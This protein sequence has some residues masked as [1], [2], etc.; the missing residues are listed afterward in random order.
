[1]ETFLILIVCVYA[2]LFIIVLVV[3]KILGGGM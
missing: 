3:S 1:M 2:V